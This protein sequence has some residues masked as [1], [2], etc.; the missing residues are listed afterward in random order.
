MLS[1]WVPTFTLVLS[2]R[3]GLQT[4]E[5]RSSGVVRDVFGAGSACMEAGC[6]LMGPRWLVPILIPIP[7]LSVSTV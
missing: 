3:D 6:S 5:G 2:I 1:F 4:A 7:I